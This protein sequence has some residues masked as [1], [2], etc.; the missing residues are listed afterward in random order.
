MSMRRSAHLAR[1][2]QCSPAMVF[3]NRFWIRLG[4]LAVALVCLNAF[5][6]EPW[7]TIQTDPMIVKTRRRAGTE[8]K[9]V[10][11]EGD[12]AADPLDIQNTL[13]D[14]R[15][16]PEFMPYIAEARYIGTPDPDGATYTYSKLDLPVLTSRDFI[17]KGYL[18]RDAT[19]DPQG[20]FSNHW[21]AT[22]NKTP[23]RS[24]V[25]RLEISE[26]SWLVTPT[27][28]GKSHAIY[29]FAADIGGS[30]PA[31]AANRTNASS[32]GDTFRNVER[33]AQKRG[34]ERVA[35]AKAAAPGVVLA[36]ASDGGPAIVPAV[37]P[38]P[39]LAVAPALDGGVHSPSVVPVS[40]VVPAPHAADAGTV[41]A[42][43]IKP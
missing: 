26:G 42:K 35:R 23:H 36:A 32:C 24:N 41:A 3:S 10:W 22:P 9:E 21:F 1:F 7:E 25:I 28:P 11:A 39:A 6:E 29:K 4:G 43:K 27:G 2:M 13:L 40:A 14:V 31:F 38:G 16:F 12:L 34:V 20:V 8:V 15:R 5:A 37:A 17:H 18:D 30:V 19:K 33:E